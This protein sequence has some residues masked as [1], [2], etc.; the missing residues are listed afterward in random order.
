MKVAYQKGKPIFCNNIC[1]N[2]S[3]E[4]VLKACDIV[5][6]A[7]DEDLRHRIPTST[8]PYYPNPRR[9]DEVEDEDLRINWRK[10][11]RV[12][13]NVYK[14]YQAYK[15]SGFE[16]EFMDE[17]LRINW[18]KVAKAAKA[19]HKGYMIYKNGGYADELEDEDLR[20]NWG[21]AVRVG[22]AIY[23]GYRAYN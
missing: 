3:N 1:P 23:K 18:R 8:G 15:N 22:H 5:C 14:G 9:W 11:A 2:V 19:L 20:I 4:K 7:E 12:G 16:D 10:A 21:K 13:R 17:D 6:S